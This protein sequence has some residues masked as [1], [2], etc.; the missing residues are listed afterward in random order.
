MYIATQNNGKYRYVYLKSTYRE[1]GKVKSKIIKN[2][3]RYD[4]LE[5]KDPNFLQK[6]KDKYE[7]P[8]VQAT[9]DKENELNQLVASLND[10][11]TDT[12]QNDLSSNA[13]CTAAIYESNFLALSVARCCSNVFDS[14]KTL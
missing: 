13:C 4:E 10:D 8:K 11:T 14:S 6:L 1:N 2:L 5:K 7:A 3:G 12:L 9:L